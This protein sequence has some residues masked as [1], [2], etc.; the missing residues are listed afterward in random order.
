MGSGPRPSHAAPPKGELQTGAKLGWAQGRGRSQQHVPVTAQPPSLRPGRDTAPCPTL[1]F[2]R[3]AGA[4]HGAWSRLVTARL[5]AG[6]HSPSASFDAVGERSPS[7]PAQR[8]VETAAVP[9][10]PPVVQWSAHDS[11]GLRLRVPGAR[12]LDVHPCVSA[13]SV[14]RAEG[15]GRSIALV[16]HPVWDTV[17]VGTDAKNAAQ[18]IRPAGAGWPAPT[19]A[20]P[21]DSDAAGLAPRDPRAPEW[22]RYTRALV[23]GARSSAPEA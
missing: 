14:R 15:P 10:R 4:G 9:V 16:A 11:D 18:P 23:R 17:R 6:P 21:H 2:P 1:S 20:R 8:R 13:S 7:C 22:R 19:G 12:G 3:S 5:A